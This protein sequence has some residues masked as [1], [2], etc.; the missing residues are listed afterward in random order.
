MKVLEL[1]QTE[2]KDGIEELKDCYRYIC[3]NNN[4]KVVCQ[5]DSD[6]KLNNDEINIKIKEILNKK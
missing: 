3:Q 4:N 2:W 1:Q 6:T 5:F